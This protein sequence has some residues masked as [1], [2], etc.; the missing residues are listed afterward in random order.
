MVHAENRI[1]EESFN[2]R[3][4]HRLR[5]LIF[6]QAVPS[7]ETILHKF[8]KDE[9]RARETIL[10]MARGLTPILDELLQWLVDNGFNASGQVK[11]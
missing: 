5:Q 4:L 11:A 3:D 2:S 10:K 1:N 9:V 7:R 6:L 8:S